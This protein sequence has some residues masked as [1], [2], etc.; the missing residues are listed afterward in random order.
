MNFDENEIIEA[1]WFTYEQLIDM[2]DELRDY[3]YIISAIKR[4]REKDIKPLDTITIR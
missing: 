4:Y 3:D 1:K 2:K